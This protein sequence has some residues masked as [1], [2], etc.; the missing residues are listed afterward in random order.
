VR[1][2]ELFKYFV[3]SFLRY[4]NIILTKIGFEE[5]YTVTNKMFEYLQRYVTYLTN[6]NS[7]LNK[8]NE[9]SFLQQTVMLVIYSLFNSVQGYN[10]RDEIKEK[11]SEIQ[12]KSFAALASNDLTKECSRISYGVIFHIVDLVIEV[13]DEQYLSALAPLLYYLVGHKYLSDYLLATYKQLKDKLYLLNKK[14]GAEYKKKCEELKMTDEEVKTLLDEHSFLS[15]KLNFGYVPLVPY[16]AK[17]KSYHKRPLAPE[18]QYIARLK[19]T[20][21]NIDF[22][23][24]KVAE[25]NGASNVGIFE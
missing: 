24:C 19:D 25:K 5:L 3:L 2:V 7:K 21:G 13:P 20:I 12:G 15:D 11:Y 4:L 6:E 22:L 17:E 23:G 8:A 9:G 18:K 14:L 16:F 1:N 10:P